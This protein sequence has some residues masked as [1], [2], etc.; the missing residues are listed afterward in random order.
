MARY[1]DL[2]A[3]KPSCEMWAH[4]TEDHMIGKAKI[5]LI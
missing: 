4:V 5:E 1:Q 2:L 3:I